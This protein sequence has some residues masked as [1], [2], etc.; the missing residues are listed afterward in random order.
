MG[1]W[2]R[3]DNNKTNDG[4]DGRV[5]RFFA[6]GESGGG[7]QK[8]RA[9]RF[10]IVVA[11]NGK[12]GRSRRG[13]G[14]LDEPSQLGIPF[15][16]P[17]STLTA[18]GCTIP[19]FVIARLIHHFDHRPSLSC[20]W[21]HHVPPSSAGSRDKNEESRLDWRLPGR[22]G[23]VEVPAHSVC[24]RCRL[25]TA[26]SAQAQAPSR[27]S[28]RVSSTLDRQQRRREPPLGR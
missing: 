2:L 22:V 28:A 8:K 3:G 6:T 4:C 14:R 27:E 12:G 13:L 21:H 9:C 20:S 15:V 25:T 1:C 24:S 17:A 26:S 7:G 19:S 10:S 5:Y 23:A 11:E 16:P 18:V